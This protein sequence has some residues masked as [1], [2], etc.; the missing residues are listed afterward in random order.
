M[1]EV[2]KNGPFCAIASEETI[3]DNDDFIWPSIHV[4][5]VAVAVAAAV[6]VDGD[7]VVVAVCRCPKPSRGWPRPR[8]SSRRPRRRAPQSA[9][10]VRTSRSFG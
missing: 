5:V 2:Q 8:R 3:N 7:V 9:P 10:S 4:A 1:F 6:V